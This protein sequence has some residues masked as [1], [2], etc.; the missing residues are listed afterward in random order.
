MRSGRRQ[1]DARYH[2]SRKLV[3]R[4]SLFLTAAKPKV[5]RKITLRAN[6]REFRT[7]FCAS[8]LGTGKPSCRSDQNPGHSYQIELAPLT[9]STEKRVV[10]TSRALASAR[11]TIRSFVSERI[12]G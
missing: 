2:A 11:Q 5:E 6:F 9:A 10:V 4:R 12:A 3:D 1:R 7:L 8:P